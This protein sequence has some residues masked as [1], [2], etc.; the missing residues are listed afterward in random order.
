MKVI[1]ITDVTFVAAGGAKMVDLGDLTRETFLARFE[2][3][4]R[5]AAA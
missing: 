4:L 3:D 2:E 5:R 1:G